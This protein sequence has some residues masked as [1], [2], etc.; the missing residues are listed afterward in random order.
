MMESI[1]RTLDRRAAFRLADSVEQLSCCINDLTL[2][3]SVLTKTKDVGG[4]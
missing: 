4:K 2:I 3:L 1:A